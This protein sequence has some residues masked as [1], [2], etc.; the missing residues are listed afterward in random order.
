MAV[1]V[2]CIQKVRCLIDV[3]V[4]ITATDRNG[5]TFYHLAARGGKTEVIESLIE[6]VDLSSAN[7]DGDTP[8]H[9]AAKFGRGDVVRLLIDKS[10]MDA[11]NKSVYICMQSL[12]YI[13]M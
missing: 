4:D 2:D 10:N 9:L 11:R 6:Q 1:E 13:V 5:N 12:A 3:G 7:S 8:L